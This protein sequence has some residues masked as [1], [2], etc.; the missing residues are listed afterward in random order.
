MFTWR[1]W[2]LLGVLFA[3]QASRIE[4]YC[5]HCGYPCHYGYC[6]DHWTAGD[7]VIASVVFVIIFVSIIISIVAACCMRCCSM[8]C[9]RAVHVPN[10][11]IE[12][13]PHQMEPYVII[14]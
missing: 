7:I 4:A 13:T 1:F 10:G 6:Y 11:A 3:L 9:K 8:C 14:A 5:H 12:A 2:V